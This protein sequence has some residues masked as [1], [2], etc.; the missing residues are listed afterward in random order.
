[1]EGDGRT[2]RKG[3]PQVSG[4]YRDSQFLLLLL[5]TVIC[6]F[7]GG[8]AVSDASAQ[9]TTPSDATEETE[10]ITSLRRSRPAPFDGVL[11]NVPAAARLLVDIT[12]RNAQCQVE[13]DRQ[14]GL[15]RASMQL[16]IDSEISRREA[17]QHL[18]DEMMTIRGRQIEQLTSRLRPPEWYERGEFWFGV[19]AV[20]GI[21]VG[22]AVTVLSAYALNLVGGSG[23]P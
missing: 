9:V 5:V 2:Q 4:K 8:A 12:Y 7:F 18:Y 10:F 14:L 15:Q 1:V 19:G 3:T 13:V 20:V 21:V 6:L 23:S 11:L 17:L 22:V 16:R